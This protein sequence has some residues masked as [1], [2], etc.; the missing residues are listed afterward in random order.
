MPWVTRKRDWSVSGGCAIRRSKVSFVHDDLDPRRSA[1]SRPGYAR[2]GRGLLGGFLL[3]LALARLLLDD[4]LGRL[5][6]D[7]ALGVEALAAGA[8]GDLL[9]VAHREQR[10]LLAVELRELG[11]QHG[12]DRDVDADAERVG[13]GRSA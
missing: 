2:P 9:E 4:V 13:A 12:A 3:P 10:V 6:D 11:E 8:P 5:G 7:A 1:A